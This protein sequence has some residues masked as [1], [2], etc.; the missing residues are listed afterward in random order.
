M[1]L[2]EYC[3]AEAESLRHR[4]DGKAVAVWLRRYAGL[5][6]ARRRAKQDAALARDPDQQRAAMMVV[7]YYDARFGTR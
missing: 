3:E 2:A 6:D 5:A 7:E 1:T 4:P